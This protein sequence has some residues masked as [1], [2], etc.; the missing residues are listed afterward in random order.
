MISTSSPVLGFMESKHLWTRLGISIG[1]AGSVEGL[2]KMN[3]RSVRHTL[4]VLPSPVSLRYISAGSILLYKNIVTKTSCIA[5]TTVLSD[6][7]NAIV[8]RVGWIS[9]EMLAALNWNQFW[10][11]EIVKYNVHP[12]C[13][14]VNRVGVDRIP[15]LIL[16]FVRPLIYNLLLRPVIDK[17]KL[18]TVNFYLVLRF[19]WMLPEYS[20]MTTVKVPPFPTMFL[21]MCRLWPT[22]DYNCNSK[23]NRRD[24]QCEPTM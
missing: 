18:A 10:K 4:D 20:P 2:G 21:E 6:D 8:E 19:G 3:T 23:C 12:N 9:P 1:V 13:I 11:I 5:R 24:T 16:Y 17:T 22:W 14:S 7:K 15:D